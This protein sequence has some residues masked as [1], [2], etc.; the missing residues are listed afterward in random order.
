M[1]KSIEELQKINTKNLLRYYKAERDR[2]YGSGYWCGCGCGQ[3]IWDA[4]VIEA[5]MEEKY[6]EHNEYLIL[7]KN[8]LNSREHINK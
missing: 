8:E 6:N 3:M 4:Y 2:F 5:D 1:R 7:I